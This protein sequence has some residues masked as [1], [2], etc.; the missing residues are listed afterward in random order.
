MSIFAELC[1]KQFVKTCSAEAEVVVSLDTPIVPLPS[2]SSAVHSFWSP[3]LC[4][5]LRL[6]IS[7]AS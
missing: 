5:S 6:A 3:A 4:M 2:G 1:N 7:V